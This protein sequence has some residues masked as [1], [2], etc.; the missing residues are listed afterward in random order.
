MSHK[1]QKQEFDRK[2]QQVESSEDPEIPWQCINSGQ[3]EASQ[4]VQHYGDIQTNQGA[5]DGR[6][7]EN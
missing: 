2:R 3:A 6:T 1:P 7:T 5:S 4:L